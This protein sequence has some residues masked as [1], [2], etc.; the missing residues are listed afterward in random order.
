[1][2]KIKLISLVNIQLSASVGVV[3][4]R[5]RPL[6]PIKYFTQA[7]INQGKIAYRP[8]AAAPHMREI[9]AFS[10]SGKKLV[11]LLA[12]HQAHRNI[13]SISKELGLLFT[14]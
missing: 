7:D 9:T 3:E 5:D 4:H 10:F 11:S 6:S 14:L 12:L 8:P 1:M 13:L 2:L